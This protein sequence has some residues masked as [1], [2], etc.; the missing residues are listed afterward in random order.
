MAG[1]RLGGLQIVEKSVEALEVAFPETVVALQ[2]ALELLERRG[3]QG[4]DAA[5]GV[6]AN[7]DQSGVTEDAQMFGDLGLAETEATDQV[8]DGT[9]AMA[10]EFDNVQ[11]V[12]LG[13]CAEGGDHGEIQYA[14]T[15]I[16]LSR[17]I[18]SQTYYKKR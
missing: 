5:L 16:F 13:E 8:A 3:A 2:P 17:N 9:R 6:D 7:G 4:V 11:A 18:P 14:S 1:F 10:E 15:N 12:G